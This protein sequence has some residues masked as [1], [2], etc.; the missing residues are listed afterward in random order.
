M[1][2]EPHLLCI[3]YRIFSI[4]KGPESRLY[5]C[6][7]SGMKRCQKLILYPIMCMWWSYWAVFLFV[8]LAPPWSCVCVRKHPCLVVCQSG[9]WQRRSIVGRWIA[10][11]CSPAEAVESDQSEQWQED[12]NKQRW[13]KK[14]WGRQRERGTPEAGNTNT[15]TRKRATAGD[16]EWKCFVLSPQQS[17][18]AEDA[19][20]AFRQSHANV[21]GQHT[22]SLLILLIFRFRSANLS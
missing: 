1:V 4:T 12:I 21:S 3:F 17:L 13:N 20:S 22:L 18:S 16:E 9:F 5:F 10:A 6:P 11:P 8:A 2:Y 7:S 19:V 15:K 14:K